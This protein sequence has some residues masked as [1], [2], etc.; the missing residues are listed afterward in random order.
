VGGLASSVGA[1]R[2]VYKA[3]II[4]SSASI[5]LCHNH[6]LCGD[7]HKGCYAEFRIMRRNLRQCP[8]S[9]G[10]SNAGVRIIIGCQEKRALCRWL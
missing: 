3:A 6:P 4:N 8:L 5:I 7:T 10:M 1:P 9:Q 2:E